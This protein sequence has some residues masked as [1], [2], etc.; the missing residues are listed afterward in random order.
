[1]R[2]VGLPRGFTVRIG[3]AHCLGKTSCGMCKSRGRVLPQDAGDAA[4][5]SSL[6]AM[7]VLV[8]RQGLE[9]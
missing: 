6:A 3:D 7:P 8:R 9:P 2:G 5:R 1:M 4:L